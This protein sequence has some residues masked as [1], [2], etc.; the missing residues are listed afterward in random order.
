MSTIRNKVLLI[1]NL[2]N[3]PEVKTLKKAKKSPI[4]PWQPMNFIKILTGKNCRDYREVCLKGKEIALEGKL[5]YRSYESEDY[6]RYVTEVVTNKILFL[7][8]DS[9]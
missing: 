2:E 3:D 5:T 7:G 1:G 4:S 8:D 6:K 9:I